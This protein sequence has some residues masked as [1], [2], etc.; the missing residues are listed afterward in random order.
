MQSSYLVKVKPA[1][2]DDGLTRESMPGLRP[3]APRRV[4]RT[5]E[6]TGGPGKGQQGSS[7]QHDKGTMLLKIAGSGCGEE[8]AGHESGNATQLPTPPLR[9]VGN[10]MLPTPMRHS[11]LLCSPSPQDAPHL[12]GM[13]PTPM[14]PIPTGCSP[15]LWDTSTPTGHGEWDALYPYGILPTPTGHSPLQRSPPLWDAPHP[16]PM[17]CGEW[18]APHPYGMLST[19]TVPT[20]TPYGPWRMGSYLTVP[21]KDDYP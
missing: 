5:E 17:D 1:G 13:L 11:P 4:E 10:G 9:A 21:S 14:L 6:D 2:S 20:P 16:K 8:A 15:P 7:S 19:A 12:Y 3:D 18:D